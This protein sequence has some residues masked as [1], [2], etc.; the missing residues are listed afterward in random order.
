MWFPTILAP[1]LSLLAPLLSHPSAI[2]EHTSKH[3]EVAH[4]DV[5]V[6]KPLYAEP[7]DPNLIAFSIEADRWPDWAGYEVGQPNTYA[8]QLFDNLQERTG[9]PPAVRVGGALI[10][11]SLAPS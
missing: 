4:L 9:Y 6:R 11:P 10:R 3:I 7:L 1:C 8:R 2:A 5:P